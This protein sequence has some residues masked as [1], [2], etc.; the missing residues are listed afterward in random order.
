MNKQ[1]IDTLKNLGVPVSFQTYSGTE[2]TYVTFFTYLE[3]VESY[4]DNK[5][6][7]IGNYTQVDVWSKGDYTTLVSSVLEALKQA[8]FRRTYI[9]ELYENDTKLYHKVIRITKNEG[10][11]Q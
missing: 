7:S 3:N 8:E 10:V 2:T 9:T 1:I 6:T 4:A 5:E 11:I